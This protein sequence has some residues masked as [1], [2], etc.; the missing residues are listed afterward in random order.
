[1]NAI[2][3]IEADQFAVN[4]AT[5][6]DVMVPT[7][8]PSQLVPVKASGLELWDRQGKR[9]LD[10][11]SGIGVTGLGHCAPDVVAAL[12]EQALQAYLARA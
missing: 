8:S 5:F 1:M 12:V 9:Y 4:R 6:D 3:S 7:Y 2:T 11:T 10:F